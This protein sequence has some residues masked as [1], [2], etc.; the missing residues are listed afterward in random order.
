[1]KIIYSAALL[2]SAELANAAI[3]AD[4]LWT[5]QDWYDDKSKVGVINGELYS[6]DDNRARLLASP[7][8]FDGTI[9][10]Y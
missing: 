8:S 2:L 1:M 6:N 7:I 5:G 4:G 10:D 3:V 9:D